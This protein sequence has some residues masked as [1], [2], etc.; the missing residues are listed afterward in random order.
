MRD[1]RDYVRQ[2]NN[3][4]KKEIVGEIV[5][6]VSIVMDRIENHEHRIVTFE[7]S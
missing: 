5:D 3:R 7:K 1:M 2:E 4:M 6:V